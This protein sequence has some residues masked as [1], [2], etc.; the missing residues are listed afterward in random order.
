MYDFE[1]FITSLSIVL[2]YLLFIDVISSQE[3]TIRGNVVNLALNMDFYW[4][5]SQY[6]CKP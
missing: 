2:S 6:K 1:M 4:H 3:D 5:E